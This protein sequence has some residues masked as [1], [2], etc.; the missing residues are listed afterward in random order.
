MAVSPA[1]F[2]VTSMGE[3]ADQLMLRQLRSELDFYKSL[4]FEYGQ[5]L[6]GIAETLAAGNPVSIAIGRKPAANGIGRK[7]KR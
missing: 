2:R 5:S 7:G 3:A 4:A 6:E 1:S